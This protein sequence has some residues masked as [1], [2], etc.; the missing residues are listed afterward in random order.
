M[1]AIVREARERINRENAAR[2]AFEAKEKREQEIHDTMEFLRK[3][4][5]YRS[6]EEI[7][8]QEKKD[9][10]A[11]VLKQ[12]QELEDFNRNLAHLLN[13]GESPYKPAEPI[14]S[15]KKPAE[16]GEQR[17]RKH[18]VEVNRIKCGKAPKMDLATLHEERFVVDL[19]RAAKNDLLT[20]RNNP[21]VFR[22]I[23][24]YIVS[25]GNHPKY[26]NESDSSISHR[27][28]VIFKQC[29]GCHHDQGY[30]NHCTGGIT[31]EYG[32]G[33]YKPVPLIYKMHRTKND[34]GAGIW[35]P[36][37]YETLRVY[38]KC[39]YGKPQKQG[40]GNLPCWYDG[41]GSATC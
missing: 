37:T 36:H 6:P 5:D 39:R 40:I 2:A 20:N 15:P 11:L 10:A 23:V 14:V 26:P 32:G 12:K 25:H 33:E 19:M 21:E 4:P 13:M 28:N 29:I 8:I 34:V 27:Y 9:A 30:H 31:R 22:N 18:T 24:E 3:N 38:S 17:A 1:D 41:D 7:A 35:V 16:H